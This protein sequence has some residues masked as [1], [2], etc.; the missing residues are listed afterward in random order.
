MY[1]TFIW[2]CLEV[3]ILDTLSAVDSFHRQGKIGEF[4]LSNFAAWQVYD[5][6]CCVY[7]PQLLI[8][9]RNFCDTQIP[10]RY[11]KSREFVT[12]KASLSL[13]YIKECTMRSPEKFKLSS[14]RASEGIYSYLVKMQA[15][16]YNVR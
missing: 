1:S 14:Y 9:S 12:A 13:Q 16:T 3:P 5:I 7:Y 8:P 4:G 11:R 6:P 15:I 2:P 10:Y